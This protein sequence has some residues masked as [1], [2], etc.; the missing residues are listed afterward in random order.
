M[1]SIRV[2]VKT[3]LETVRATQQGCSSS[4]PDCRPSCCLLVLTE[5]TVQKMAPVADWVRKATIAVLPEA[6]THAQQDAE[7][8]EQRKQALT[9]AIAAGQ[10]VA[11]SP[12]PP[13]LPTF[14]A[15]SSDFGTHIAESITHAVEP[16][17]KK[18]EAKFGDKPPAQSAAAGSRIEVAA[19]GPQPLQV[20]GAS[21]AAVVDPERVQAKDQTAL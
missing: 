17:T 1:A 4:V 21:A 13:Q 19:A 10:P 3:S 11:L 12:P 5:V 7:R 9:A 6:L 14:A 2:V 20:E 8:E 16:I 15:A 18:W